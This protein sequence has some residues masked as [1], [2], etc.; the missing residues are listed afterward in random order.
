MLMAAIDSTQQ[1]Q[2]YVNGQLIK[3][4]KISI[5]AGTPG[6]HTISGYM[7]IKRSCRKC[8]NEETLHKIIG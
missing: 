3:G 8:Y 2:V 7:L 1:P 5:K 6:K 4:N